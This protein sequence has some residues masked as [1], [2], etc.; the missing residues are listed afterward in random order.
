MSRQNNSHKH[1]RRS[2]RW[3]G[4]DYGTAAYY[5]ITI[6][7]HQRQHLFTDLQLKDIAAKSWQTLPTHPKSQHIALDQWI[8][9]PNHMHGILIIEQQRLNDLDHNP[10]LFRNV[11]SGKLGR[12]IATYKAA[13][14]RQINHLRDTQGAKVWQRG[15][16]DRVIRNEQELHAI[17]QYIQDNPIRWA[18]DRENLDTL[19]N[20][21]THRP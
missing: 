14:T 15:Y 20:K 10:S 12:F 3:K 9:M 8:I 5:F 17:R 21:M 6:C 2:I 18:E 1:H 13:T 4:W 19:T 16:W 7:T 11:A